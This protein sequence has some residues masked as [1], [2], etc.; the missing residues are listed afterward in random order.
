M[1]F[2]T[3][4]L[5]EITNGMRTKRGRTESYL[6]E[7][8]RKLW[9]KSLSVSASN[10]RKYSVESNIAEKSSKMRNEN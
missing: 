7:A 9:N 10:R 8:R 1:L 6:W 5:V 4:R 2:K 3:M